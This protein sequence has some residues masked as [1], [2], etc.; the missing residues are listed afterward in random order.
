MKLPRDYARFTL[1]FLQLRLFTIFSIV[2]TELVNTGGSNSK[3]L[4][5]QFDR[6]MSFLNHDD[7][8][9]YLGVVERHTKIDADTT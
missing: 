3:V 7:N 1:T 8:L 6:M 9:S 4:G 2:C 5:N